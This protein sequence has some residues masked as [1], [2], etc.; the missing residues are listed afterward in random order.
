MKRN[1]YIPLL[2][3]FFFQLGFSQEHHLKRYEYYYYSESSD[4]IEPYSMNEYFYEN[5]SRYSFR[6]RYFGSNTPELDRIV[7]T[8]NSKTNN[9][10]EYFLSYTIDYHQYIER[11]Y[12]YQVDG[13]LQKNETI[14]SWEL[15]DTIKHTTTYHGGECRPDSIVTIYNLESYPNEKII[16]S[17][18]TLLETK[19]NYI[20]DSENEEGWTYVW[21]ETKET[22]A[23]GK[24]ITCW[25]DKG[26]SYGIPEQLTITEYD[27][28]GDIIYTEAHLRRDED[29]E[30]KLLRQYYY[31]R[32]YNDDDL[33]LEEKELEVGIHACGGMIN[34]STLTTYE[35]DQ[36]GIILNKKV[37]SNEILSSEDIY[38]SYGLIS[39]QK[40]YSYNRVSSE[41]RYFYEEVAI[42]EAKKENIQID[43]FPNPTSDQIQINSQ[44]LIYDNTYLN[45]FDASGRF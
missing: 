18:E 26:A 43:V 45:L 6:Y 2:F 27:D 13:C 16:F 3:V 36:N 23:D 10:I 34:D 44:A 40:S 30:L 25:N 31:S 42:S 19:T 29:D 9:D 41:Y 38:N 37:F 7:E 33:I 8:K 14:E 35:Y 1:I 32:I 22:S 11:K 21:S 12:T 15:G 5:D 20:D 17:Y 4:Q 39:I 24:R 28:R